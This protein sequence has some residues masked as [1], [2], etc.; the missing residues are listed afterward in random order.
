[1]KIVVVGSG[2]IGTAVQSLY[3]VEM[4][5]ILHSRQRSA[6]ASFGHPAGYR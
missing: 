4:G 2:P 1:M 5:V 6:A 3:I